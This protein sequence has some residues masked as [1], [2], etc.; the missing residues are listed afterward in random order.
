M[1]IRRSRLSFYPAWP[2][3]VDRFIRAVDHPGHPH[4]G[5][6]REFLMRL[7]A[8]PAAVLDRVR[9]RR[10]LLHQPWDLDFDSAQ[11]IVAAGIGHLSGSGS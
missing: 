5:Y 3:L 11:W 2:D 8:E 9:P 7:G 10:T 6:R 1:R 4:W